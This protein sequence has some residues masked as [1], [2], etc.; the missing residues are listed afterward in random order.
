MFSS[1]AGLKEFGGRL[2]Y[3]IDSRT[4]KRDYRKCCSIV[5]FSVQT[6]CLVRDEFVLRVRFRSIEYLKCVL[7]LTICVIGLSGEKWF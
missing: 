3:R 1:F 2:G 6:M 5:M 7:D 4:I